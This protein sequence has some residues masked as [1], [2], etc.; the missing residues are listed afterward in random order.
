[1]PLAAGSPARSTTC[2]PTIAY[3]P[4]PMASATSSADSGAGQ[5]R[6]HATV[7]ARR[8]PMAST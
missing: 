2:A 7:R 6:V 1:M 8:P 4:S 3:A 5:R